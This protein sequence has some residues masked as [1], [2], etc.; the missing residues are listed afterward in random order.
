LRLLGTLVQVSSRGAVTRRG[1]IVI[2]VVVVLLAGGSVA[3]ARSLL[4]GPDC[5]VTAADGTPAVELSRP[6]AEAV[7]TA[8][9]PEVRRGRSVRDAVRRAAPDLSATQVRVVAGAVSG[10]RHAALSCRDGGASSSGSAG[11]DSNGLTARAERVR[12]DVLARFGDLPLGGFAPG[13]VHNGH[14]PGSAHY[15]G[16]A[17]DVFF[18]PISAGSKD[19]GWALAQ[20]LV[21]QAQRLSIA[22]VIFD[23][24]IWTA[25]RGA[26]GWRHYVVPD[27]ENAHNEAERKILEHRDHVHVDVPR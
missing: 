22:T 10:D 21:A 16:R 23:D 15:E 19:R 18:R 26:D 5:V 14:M 11:L 27:L 9:A 4:T 1:R 12:A 8:A 25:D 24:Q 13:G 3:V 6:E 7:T 2:A 20:Y 17:I